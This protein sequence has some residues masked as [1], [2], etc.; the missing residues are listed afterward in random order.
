MK[1]I[2]GVFLVA[3]LG[4]VP[5]AGYSDSD[6]ESLSPEVRALLRQEMIA[7]QEGMKSMVPA[8]ASGDLNGVSA[9]AGKISRSFILE[10]NI[11]EEQ[12]REL[13]QTLSKDFLAKD[14]Q[15]H[16]YAAMLEHV[17]K[18]GH[19]ELVAFY[20]SRLMESCAGCHSQHAVHRF[21]AFRSAPESQGHHHQGVSE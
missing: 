13:H 21:P 17:S 14:R 8:F 5:V 3:L 15:F 12:A 7:I 6:V 19:A 11:S 9:I 10:Q 2:A 4:A 1:T 18:A 20:Y 16:Q